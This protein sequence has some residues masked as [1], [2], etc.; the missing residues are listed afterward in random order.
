[1]KVN[2]KKLTVSLFKGFYLD[3]TER[4]NKKYKIRKKIIITHPLNT[5][6]LVGAARERE[7]LTVPL[8]K[9]VNSYIIC[10]PKQFGLKNKVTH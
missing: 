8:R 1:M 4:D 7:S 6:V 9:G 10:I 5:G 2:L 3:P